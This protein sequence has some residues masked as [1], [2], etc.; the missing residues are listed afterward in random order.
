M[1][2]KLT[3]ILCAD[4]YG[5]SRLMGDDEEAT[6]TALTSHRRKIDSLI[7]Q[8]HGRFVNSAGDSVLA[9]FAS[10]VEA[11]NCAVEMQ[12]AVM[13]A[14]VN[15]PPQR[16]MEFRVG[17]NLGDV[18]AEGEQIYGD[19]VNVAARLESLAEPNGICISESVYGQVRNR[20]GLTYRDIGAQRVKNIAEPVR[21]YRVVLDRTASARWRAR[22]IPHRYRT[23]LLSLTGLAIVVGTIVLVQHVS[24]R[25]P[26]TSASLAPQEKPAL[27][28]AGI[29]SLAVLPFV[30]VSGKPDEEY[31]SDGIT[32][33]LI[34]RLSRLSHLLVVAR[35]SSFTYK[36][37][38][39]T[40]QEIGREL[41]VKYLLEG[42]IRKSATRVRVNTR[43]L[44]THNG[45]EVWA[46]N[47]D[48]PLNDVFSVQD[49]V[50]QKIVTTLNL[51]LNLA[52]RG[53]LT[54]QTTDNLEAYDD[55][56]RGLDYSW[57]ENKDDDA[58]AFELYKKAIELDPNYADAYVLMGSTLLN[59][60]WWEWSQDQHAVER[61]QALMH[62]ALELDN[63][64]ATAHFILGIT[65]AEQGQV[66]VALSEAHRGIA[67]DPNGAT[68]NWFCSGTGAGTDWAAAS[69]LWSG[70]PAE[71][72]DIAQKAIS[73]DPERRDFHLMEVGVAYYSLGRPREAVA[74]LE[75]FVHSYPGF[76]WALYF[77]A[78]SYVESG[79]MQ[80]AHA[81]AAHIMNFN[82][83]FSLEAGMFRTVKPSDNL[84]S[85]R[86]V[87]DLRKAGL[88]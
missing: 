64:H 65:L 43:L 83:D 72:L 38:S 59:D 60:W 25:P 46:D 4:V 45:T 27:L 56:L 19:G 7:E 33:E 55:V 66:D 36:N 88:K 24:L 54:R 61:S 34:T 41:G 77:L 15:V 20:L 11:V 76:M 52:E 58:K 57:R 78:A 67:L 75:Q 3:T 6:L 48:R 82:P 17:V 69:L 62:K 44:E 79:M 1:E 35:T 74:A 86:L 68:A 26:R 80:Q 2:R 30:N 71:A 39:A 50:V 9:E 49:E 47:F 5:Y 23:G 37:K 8:H 14:N 31:F 53:L 84:V 28:T 12:G 29:P 87:A 21:V 13:A 22:S 70:K 16:R 51:Q 85:E 73:R 63:S 81:Q 42:S 18:M 32:D 10:V 40:A